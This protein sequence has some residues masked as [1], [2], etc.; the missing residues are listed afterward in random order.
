MRVAKLT[1]RVVGEGADAWAVHERALERRARGDDIILLSIGDP[2]FDTP[3]PIRVAAE[4]ALRDGRTHYSP[5][6]GEPLLRQA[7]A[8]VSSPTLARAVDPSEVV[9]F[10]GAQAALYALAQVLFDEGDEVIT[11]EPTYVTYEA[12][13]GAAG[14]AMV[15]IPLRPERGFRLD[16][17]DLARAITPRTRGLMLN[18]PHTPTGST[19]EREEGLAV[20]EL[21]R[22]HELVLISDEVYGALTYD[23]PY[24]SPAA[25]PGMADRTVVVSSLSK[26]HA[27]TGWRCGWAIAPG[28]LATH[29]ID[30][31]RCMYFGIAQF[32]QDAAAVAL[33]Q[34]GGELETIRSAYARRA[35]VMGARLATIPGLSCRIPTAGMY[36]FA[37]VRRTGLDGKQFAAGLL[38]Q[39]G[40]SVTPGEGFGPSGAGHVRIT[41]GTE[42]AGLLEASDRI[43]R[44]VAG[45]AQV[46]KAA[47]AS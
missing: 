43:E 31:A 36:L 21:C 5:I 33:A 38:D 16:P 24:Q 3:T 11:P 34:A 26:S 20:A 10:P 45:L 47:V 27:M 28:S 2:D 12:L 19:L 9:V 8:R 22:R 4:T 40:V 29:L 30:L 46:R 39:T 6:G 17:D 13:L 44:Y 23:R 25:L 1:E 42:E 41:L 15:Q 18:F 37:D 32:V 35:R 7:V 14:A